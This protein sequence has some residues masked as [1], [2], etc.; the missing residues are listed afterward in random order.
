MIATYIQNA[1]EILTALREKKP[2]VHHITNYVT[3]N[4]CA[5]I[6]LAIGGSPIMADDREEV[7]EMTAISSAL[8][9]NTGTLNERTVESMLL[10]GKKANELG[11][12]VVFDPVGA[13]ASTMRNRTAAKILSELKISVLR[14]NMS[15]VK[16]ILG[17]GSSTRGVDVSDEDAKNSGMQGLGISSRLAKHL[18]CIVAITGKVDLISDGSRVICIENGHA[19]MSDVTG[20]GCMCTSLIAACCGSTPDCFT[21]TVAAV[22]TMG[23]TGELAFESAG[24]KGTGSFRTA[25]IDAASQMNAEVFLRRARIYE[26]KL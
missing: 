1:A 4:D 7:Q 19:M 16:Y 21:A 13:G 14:G 10:A 6:V 24:E 12:P 11:I 25:L 5:N 15:E 18:H 9:L 17:L 2:L 22:S 3:V 20:T 23:I 26:A 8:L